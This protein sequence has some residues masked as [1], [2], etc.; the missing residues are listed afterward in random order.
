MRPEAV[1]EVRDRR[2]A[3]AGVLDLDPGLGLVGVGQPFGGGGLVLF[4]PGSGQGELGSI[5]GIR[6]KRGR[7]PQQSLRDSICSAEGP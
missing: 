3:G 4:D 7:A 2:R 6:R 1:R 5:P